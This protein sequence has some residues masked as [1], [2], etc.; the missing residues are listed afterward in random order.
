MNLQKEFEEFHDNIKLDDENETLREK[1]DI[2]LEKLRSHITD[3]SPSYSTFVQGSYAM[4]TG[5]K[6][7]D[8][9]YDIDVGIKFDINKDDYNALSPKIWVRDALSG[10]TKSVKIR[11]SCVT[12]TYQK[13]YDPIYHVDFAVYAGSNPDGKLY[14]A[15]GKEYSLP[16]NIKWEVSDPQGLMNLVKNKYRDADDRRQ[17]RRIIRYMKKW[18]NHNT[19]LLGNGAPSGIALTCLAFQLFTVSKNYD[20]IGKVTSYNDLSA[21]ISFTQS[22]INKFTLKYDSDTQE[23]IHKITI[24]LPVEPYNNLFAKMSDRQ[25]EILYQEL[26]KMNNKLKDANNKTKRSEACT[27]LVELFGK[28]F[29]V[30]TD[31]SYVRTSE[32][33]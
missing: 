28:E 1:R 5:I 12:V 27:L 17:F 29:P 32:S 24:N 11:R 30:T 26:V 14:V 18:K 4:G 15:K 23:Y 13:N 10:H 6:P 22:I 8:E 19:Y 9:D 20:I 21:L 7:E 16:E 2:L 33:A 3:S 25:M 31:R